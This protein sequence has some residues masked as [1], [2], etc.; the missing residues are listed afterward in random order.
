MVAK[1]LPEILL[2]DG[3]TDVSTTAGELLFASATVVPDLLV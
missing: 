1:A 2:E 3:K